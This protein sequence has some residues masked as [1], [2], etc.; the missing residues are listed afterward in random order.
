MKEEYRCLLIFDESERVKVESYLHLF[1]LNIFVTIYI[2]S[3]L[4]HID[5]K[6]QS[7]PKKESNRK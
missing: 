3:L 2:I 7:E 1:L 5:Q 4:F 6:P